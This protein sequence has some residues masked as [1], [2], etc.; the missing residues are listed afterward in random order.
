[1]RLYIEMLDSVCNVNNWKHVDEVTISEGEASDIYFQIINK[2][3]HIR[4]M[5]QATSYSVSAIFPDVD[6]SQTIE[7]AASQP[8]ADD[9]SIWKVSLGSSQ[10]P[11]SGTFLVKLTEDGV[12][13]TL[14]AEL[15]IR[16]ELI[17]DGGC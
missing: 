1:M 16:V 5:T 7:V 11:G 6:E 13:R 15:G 2:S 9:K 10:T 17:N 12:E 3:Q 4:Y 8:F 14:K